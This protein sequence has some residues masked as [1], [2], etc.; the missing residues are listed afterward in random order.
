MANSSRCTVASSA[1]VAG[2]SGPAIDARA[3]ATVTSPAYPVGVSCAR[4]AASRTCCNS[5]PDN[6]SDIRC[7][8]PRDRCRRW[9]AGGSARARRSISTAAFCTRPADRPTSTRTFGL[10]TRSRARTVS[11]DTEQFS[12]TGQHG[13]GLHA[14]P[15]PTQKQRGRSTNDAATM[16]TKATAGRRWCLTGGRCGETVKHDG[17]PGHA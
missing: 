15:C 2:T 5:S 16:P 1:R 4:F 14:A 6:R 7:S 17:N 11:L 13:S 12:W 9:R 10:D 3:A 8:R